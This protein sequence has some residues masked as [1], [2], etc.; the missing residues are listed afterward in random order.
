LQIATQDGYTLQALD[1]ARNYQYRRKAPMFDY[2]SEAQP[3]APDTV[4]VLRDRLSSDLRAAMK[5]RDR[6]RTQKVA[7]PE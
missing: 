2:D 6:G 3:R 4:G 7:D 1:P 5:A